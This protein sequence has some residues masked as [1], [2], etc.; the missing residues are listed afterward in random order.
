MRRPARGGLELPELVGDIPSRSHEVA[1]VPAPMAPQLHDALE[2][3]GFITETWRT[4]PL[5][6]VPLGNVV[7]D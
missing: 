7:V 6:A 5:A 4:H 3:L 1:E 2:A